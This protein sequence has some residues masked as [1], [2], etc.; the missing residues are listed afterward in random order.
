[1][2]LGS[3]KSTTKEKKKDYCAL[4]PRFNFFGLNFRHEFSR[5]QKPTTYSLSVWQKGKSNSP[6]YIQCEYCKFIPIYFKFN[7]NKL[8]TWNGLLS[9]AFQKGSYSL[10]KGLFFPAQG[11]LYILLIWLAIYLLFP[12]FA[13]NCT[14][15]RDTK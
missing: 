5:F 1:M 7:T 4:P 2:I 13:D 6:G 15:V 9:N 12:Q 11:I 3:I 10:R 14:E 8:W